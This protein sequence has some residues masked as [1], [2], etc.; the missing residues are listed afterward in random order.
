MASEGGSSDVESDHGTDLLTSR[1][2]HSEKDDEEEEQERGGNEKRTVRVL[3]CLR[4]WW[5]T[6]VI[7]GTPLL[8]SPL[9]LSLHSTEAMAAYAIAIIAVYW[10]TEAL[11]LA[12][13][14]LL[15]I[16]LFPALG[17]LS[18]RDTASNYL[19]D[20]NM[21]FVGGLMV[22]VAIEKWN[23][24]KRIALLVLLAVGSSPRWLLLGFMGTTAF[25]SMWMSNTA[26]AAMMLAIAHAVL[27]ELEEDS[28][29]HSNGGGLPQSAVK[30]LYSKRYSEDSGETNE[31]VSVEI[32]REGREG[33]ERDEANA[34]LLGSREMESG[35]QRSEGEDDSSLRRLARVLVL[36]VAYAAN[37]GGTA[38]LTGTGPNIVLSGLSV[39]LFPESGGINFGL[40]FVFATP[41]MVL[42]LLLSWLYLS[43]LFC[44]DSFVWVKKK[45]LKRRVRFQSGRAKRVIREQ[46]RLLGRIKYAEV[47]VLGLFVL[48][49]LL[50]LFREPRFIPGWASVFRSSGGASYFS[51]SSTAMFVVFLMFIIPSRPPCWGKGQISTIIIITLSLL[52]V[53]VYHS[54]ADTG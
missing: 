33:G 25:L 43:L 13:T 16:W 24:H 28:S 12:V 1:P 14:A 35:G 15:P 11:P 23:L 22:A 18:A 30:I 29:S 6:I 37:I 48:L 36:G 41:A 53:S 26:V 4:R 39:S 27:Q 32:G 47:V 2:R 8:L 19:S 52:R 38:T 40:W 42:T 7:L 44:D 20:T 9:P 21:L 17:V 3:H 50:W 54:V 10:V 46:Y 34:S 31:E 49:A 51:D 5:K 45:L